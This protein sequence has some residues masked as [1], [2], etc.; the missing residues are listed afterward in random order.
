MKPISAVFV[1]TVSVIC[2]FLITDKCDGAVTS[3]KVNKV[4]ELNDDNWRSVLQDEWL[5][6]L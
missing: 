4:I 3:G 2:L 6:Q 1:A 5:L